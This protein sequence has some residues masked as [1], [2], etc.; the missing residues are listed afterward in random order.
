MQQPARSLFQG[1]GRPGPVP[2]GGLLPVQ[3]LRGVL[4]GAVAQGRARSAERILILTHRGPDPDALGAC[5]GL[6]HLI[7]EGFGLQATVA[8]LGRIRRAENLALVRALEL[9]LEDYEGIDTRKFA[10]VA[11][12]DTQPEF[13]HTVLPEGLPVLAVFDHHVPPVVEGC[14]PI[15]VAHRDV[16]LNLG[17]TASMI[18]E[19]LRDAEVPLDSRTASA[20]FCGVRYDTADLSRSNSDLDEEAYYE[21]FRYADRT[22]IAE[23]HHPPLPR[24]YYIELSNALSL[25]RQHG[26]L[27]LAL[28]G[29][30]ENPETVAEMADFL[31]RMKGVS[32][33]V[34]GGAFEGEYVLSLRTDYAFGKAYPLMERVLAGEGSF[35]GHGHIAGGHLI[36]ED[37]GESTIKEVERL[38]RANALAVIATPPEGDEETIP[39]EGRLLSE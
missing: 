4:E 32:W 11:L 27:V 8:T 17:A 39:T 31:L 9:D 13:G 29:E 6:R 18:Y 10:G 24:S 33:V 22:A 30:I 38:L 26:P 1:S 35:G 7:Q 2:A 36:L 28:L 20:L 14:E 37:F 25:A 21:T 23:I 12:V 5:E 34:V 16:R 3:H 19:Y 15:G